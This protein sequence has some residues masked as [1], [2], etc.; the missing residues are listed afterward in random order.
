M[1]YIEKVDQLINRIKNEIGMFQSKQKIDFSA[2]DEK[3]DKLIK[4]IDN[5][6]ETKKLRKRVLANKTLELKKAII[7]EINKKYEKILEDIRE[8]NRKKGGRNNPFAISRRRI[9][10]KAFR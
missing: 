1:L 7:D 9:K 2:C 5:E 8:N 3:Y 6:I 10:K 4:N